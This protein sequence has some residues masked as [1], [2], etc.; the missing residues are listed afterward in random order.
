MESVARG[1]EA[2]GE[3]RSCCLRGIFVVSTV[4]AVRGIKEVLTGIWTPSQEVFYRP[5]HVGANLG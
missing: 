3:A 1:D 5:G 4:N 2:L